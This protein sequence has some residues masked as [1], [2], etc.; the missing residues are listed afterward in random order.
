MR[1]GTDLTVAGP[2]SAGRGN[3]RR[4]RTSD[5]TSMFTSHVV[6]TRLRRSRPVSRESVPCRF[7]ER[8]YWGSLPGT[9]PLS[10]ETVADPATGALED[11]RRT[12]GC[13]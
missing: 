7:A 9:I 11:R 5:R 1:L 8:V 2:A 13:Q 4:L 6:V 10:D 3:S 12:G